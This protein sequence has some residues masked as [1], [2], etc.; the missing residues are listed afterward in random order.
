MYFGV[1]FQ[2][3]AG[4]GT[5]TSNGTR[6]NPQRQKNEEIATIYEEKQKLVTESK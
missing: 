6:S 2:F 3:G 5:N 4:T 1:R